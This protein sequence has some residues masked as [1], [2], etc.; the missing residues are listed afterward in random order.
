MKK[1][2]LPFNA[3]MTLACILL[4]IY[5]SMW[6]RMSTFEARTVLDYDP[7]WQYRHAKEILENNFR[8]PEWDSLSF[9]PP[10]RPNYKSQGWNYTMALFFKIASLFVS[11]PFMEIAKIAPVIMAGLAVISAYSLG[12]FL[13]NKWGGFA[14][15]LFATLTPAFIGVSMAGYCD[16]DA[17]VIFY[18]FLAV[19][20]IFLALKKRSIPYY[21]LSILANVAF[22][23]NW[24]AGWFPLM[25]FIAF[26]PVFVV[27]RIIENIIHE[28]KLKIEIRPIATELKPFIIPLLIIAIAAN[29]ITFFLGTSNIFSSLL[30]GLR[31]T[32]IAGTP[33]LVNVSV[34]ELQ[35]I[36]I[37]T[38]S[39]FF[40]VA[41]RVGLLPTL[42]TLFGLPLL[43]LYKLIKKIKIN[44]AEIFLYLWALI[45]FYLILR[46]VRFSLLFSCATAASTGYVI[47]S[48]VKHLRRNVISATV[49]GFLTL[50]ALMFISD[51]IQLGLAGQGM[52]LSGNWYDLLD[53]LKENADEKALVA[54]WWDPGHIITGYTG[55]R[56]HADGAHCGPTDCIPY[57]HNIRIQNMGKIMSTSDESEAVDILKKYMQ[58]TPEQCEEVK[59]SFGDIVPEEA[60]ESVSEM[61]FISSNDLIGKFT[62]M[63]YFGGYRAPISS[64]A[65]F[66]KNPGVCCAVTPKSEPDQIPCGEFADQ[67]RGVWIWCPWV[68]GLSDVQQDDQGNPI[69]VYDYSGLTMSLVQKQFYLLPIYNNQYL[70]NHVTFFSDGQMQDIDLSDSSVQLEKI[71]GL[72]WIDPSFRNLIYF[73]PAIKDS[74]FTKTFFYDGKGLDHF[75]LVYSNPEIKLYKVNFD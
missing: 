61:Y 12:K 26:L 22:V 38:S 40:S 47:G 34:A 21:I 4:L 28:R 31:F 19:Y 39:G 3:I 50:L 18:F 59:Q 66:Q 17:T 36:N 7:F 13:T 41:G 24:G 69:Y 62:W 56:V 45:T 32:A 58:L 44:Y 53:W 73:A 48:L 27:F 14:T 55:L 6:V 30:V 72:V 2:K 46:G 49:F 29:V 33:M 37:L 20:S 43:V 75:E 11:I 9:F 25:L 70:I 35:L 54:T 42:M 15:A 60:C 67:G 1:F 71:D 51:A 8:A 5:L 64:G 10:G 23:Y 57:N 68:F 65:D 16:T 74:I 52:E 63:N